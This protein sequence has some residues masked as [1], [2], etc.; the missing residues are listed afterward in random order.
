[1][2]K[3]LI[4]VL[5]ASLLVGCSRV[6]ASDGEVVLE[7]GA[8]VIGSTIQGPAHIAEGATLEGAT[9]GPNTSIGPRSS[10][11]RSCVEESIILHEASLRDLS[12]R[13]TGSVIGQGVTVTGRAEGRE[14]T[15]RL[16]LGDFSQ[17]EL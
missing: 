17:V 4:L 3:W 12:R 2:N 16:V 13:V 11:V 10:I 1:M 9:V 15:L 14:G 6:Q 8:K 5:A 7:P